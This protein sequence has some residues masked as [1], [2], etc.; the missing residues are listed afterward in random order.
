MTRRIR[1]PRGL[2]VGVASLGLIASA[3]APAF[4]DVAQPTGPAPTLQ[5]PQ[6]PPPQN[7]QWVFGYHLRT[8]GP[9]IP[10]LE[11]RCTTPGQ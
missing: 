9:P 8:D 5:V 10:F 4:A 2:V 6:S 7:C 11:L 3:A 1:L